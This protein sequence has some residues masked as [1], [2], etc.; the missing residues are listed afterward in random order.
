MVAT[1]AREVDVTVAV[2][3]R[4]E[5][6]GLGGDGNGGVRS[7]KGGGD[8]GGEGGGVGGGEGGSIGG[9]TGVVKEE[10]GVV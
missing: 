3:M 2:A 1:G 5:E 9:A 8:G 7:A 10:A 6:T 4:A